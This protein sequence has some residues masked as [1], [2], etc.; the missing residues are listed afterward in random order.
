MQM[1]STL[2]LFLIPLLSL[3]FYSSCME[4][5]GFT[6]LW[7]GFEVEFEEASRPNG[8]VRRIVTKKSANQ[9]DQSTVR[10]NLVG[11]HVAEAITV[12]IGVDP[13]SS[14]V[15]GVH[16]RL[17]S[18]QVT[19]APNTSFIEV[20]IEILTGNLASEESPDLILRILDAGRTKISANYNK[21]TVEIRLACPSNLAGR[22]TTV[23]TGTGGTINS[24]VVITEIEPFTYRISDI[25]GGVYSQVYGGEPNP[26]IFTE[27]CDVITITD[28][29][30][31][32]FGTS[33]FNGTG[34]VN[35]DRTIRI[36]WNNGS[37]EG[38][39]RGVTILT[40]IP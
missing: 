31:V 13:A 34:R 8:A 7:E 14:A 20:P 30:D 27:L 36:S 24:Q 26:A 16:Y 18:T 32:V 17:P 6:I 37:D 5:S 28:Q 33:G 15:L 3:V 10:V 40:P 23:N 19:I 1:K 38:S 12:L 29:P 25:T 11:A 22:Y 9:V 2:L 21:V 35:A 4:E 39:D